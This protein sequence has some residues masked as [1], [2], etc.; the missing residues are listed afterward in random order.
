MPRN[1]NYKKN[2]QL[3]SANNGLATG[4]GDLT[5]RN[6]SNTD[7]SGLNN[8]SNGQLANLTKN[9]D[10][11]KLQEPT[12][13]SQN[14]NDL[15]SN[16]KII[17]SAYSDSTSHRALEFCKKPNTSG[18]MGRPIEV[19]ANFYAVKIDY[20]KSFYQYQVDVTKKITKKNNTDVEVFVNKDK[21]RLF[22]INFKM[23]ILTKLFS[24]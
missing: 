6:E 7:G 2:S 16:D 19:F 11:N 24:L 5:H 1:R 23:I 15:C 13:I 8:H 21:R 4:N 22:L 3:N 17:Y 9:L 10:L 20:S 18:Q 14:N 12:R